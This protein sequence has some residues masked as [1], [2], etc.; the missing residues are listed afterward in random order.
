MAVDAAGNVYIADTG[1]NAIKEWNAST[2]QVTTLVSSGLNGPQ[3]VAV[4]AAGNVYIADSGNNAIKERVRAFVPGGAVSVGPA[5][6]SDALL[7]GA[8]DHAVADRRVRPQQRPV[9]LT[10]GAVANGVV[11][12]SFTANT[13]AARTAHITVL[14]QP[15]TVTQAGT[16]LPPL[17]RN[18]FALAPMRAAGRRCGRTAP[19]TTS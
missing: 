9:W 1:N 4:D 15:I 8:A 3:G 14:G 11:H 6:G 2:Q 12:F 5:A 7:A 10:I 17:T 16:V 13:G 19:A 18:V